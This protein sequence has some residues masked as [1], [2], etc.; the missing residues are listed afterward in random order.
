[1]ARMIRDLGDRVELLEQKQIND[2]EAFISFRGRVYADK[3]WKGPAGLSETTDLN[4]PSLT[5]AQVRTALIA[6]GALKPRST[7]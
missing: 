3:R 4:D 1:M 6:R 2:R 5:K 7:N